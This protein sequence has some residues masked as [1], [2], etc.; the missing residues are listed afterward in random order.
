[1][2]SLQIREIKKE[3]IPNVAKTFS[4]P[5]HFTTLKKEEPAEEVKVEKETLIDLSNPFSSNPNSSY[6]PVIK[7]RRARITPKPK[8]KPIKE[9]PP[10][11]ESSVDLNSEEDDVI[12]I[13]S[14]GDSRI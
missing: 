6:E 1:M 10:I 8:L 5:K 3:S 9:E 11:I 13:S 12:V 4:K 7:V 14:D 2:I